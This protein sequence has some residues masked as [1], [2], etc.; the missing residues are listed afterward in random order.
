MDV[1]VIL[2]SPEQA[3]AI[4]GPRLKP[5][6]LTA[7]PLAGTFVLSPAVLADNDHKAAHGQ[8]AVLPEAVVTPDEAWPPTD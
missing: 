6:R 1:T 4:R 7:G 3:A 8:L 5:R 2:L